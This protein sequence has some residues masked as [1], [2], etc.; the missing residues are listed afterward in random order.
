MADIYRPST[1]VVKLA[2]KLHANPIAERIYPD[3]LVV[4]VFEDGRKLSFDRDDITRT[5]TEP[6]L[7][8]PETASGTGGS[9]PPSTPPAAR[10]AEADRPR[11]KKGNHE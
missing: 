2:E 9:Q 11:R 6:E 5:L 4:I 10:E 1:I 3:G 7:F 8:T